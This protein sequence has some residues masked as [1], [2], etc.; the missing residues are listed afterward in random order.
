MHIF[1]LLRCLRVRVKIK[2]CDFAEKCWPCVLCICFVRVIP[3]APF[4][5]SLLSPACEVGIR[6]G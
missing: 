2:V 5:V 1:P 3:P 6:V 4:K